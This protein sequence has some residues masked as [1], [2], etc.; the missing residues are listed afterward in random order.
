[1]LSEETAVALQELTPLVPDEE[2]ESF[3]EII[4]PSKSKK[5]LST[6][7]VKWLLGILIP[8]IFTLWLR[9]LPDKNAEEA[10][11]RQ[12]ES[13]A[14]QQREAELLENGVE[15]LQQLLEHLDQSGICVPGQFEAPPHDVQPV[16]NDADAAVQSPDMES[17][18]DEADDPKEKPDFQQQ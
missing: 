1:M 16:I 13:N 2:Q 14:I 18:E 9:T 4:K 8:M 7:N 3:A 10:N 12:A 15:A 6:E 5:L 11:Q 17:Q